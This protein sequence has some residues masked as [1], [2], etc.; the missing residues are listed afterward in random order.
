[1]RIQLIFCVE[2]DEHCK[3]DQ[4]YIKDRRDITVECENED[5]ARRGFGSISDAGPDNEVKRICGIRLIT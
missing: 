3:S 4:I 1:M 2:T 5:R